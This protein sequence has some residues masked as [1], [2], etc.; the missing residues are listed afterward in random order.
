MLFI[1]TRE[2]KVKEKNKKS[3]KAS[4]LIR[5]LIGEGISLAINT[6]LYYIKK[7]D[8]S[9]NLVV[10]VGPYYKKKVSDANNFI[11]SEYLKMT[12][13]QI[14][15]YINFE[16]INGGLDD[17]G[18]KF[19]EMN[20]GIFLCIKGFPFSQEYKQKIIKSQIEN[21]LSLPNIEFELIECNGIYLDKIEHQKSNLTSENT[22]AFFQELKQ[23]KKKVFE[24]ISNN[25]Q[26]STEYTENTIKNNTNYPFDDNNQNNNLFESNN[27]NGNYGY[28]NNQNNKIVLRNDN[29]EN[30]ED[31][32]NQNN[33]I[34]GTN[35]N[36]ENYEGCLF[37]YEN[38]EDDN[39]QNNNIFGT[40]NNNENYEGCLFGQF[41]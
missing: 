16:K 27:N 9:G 18:I 6:A 8:K 40:N 12:I 24:N 7:S 22:N 29:N 21:N 17:D 33:N 20:F 32:N 4:N 34:F 36:S 26:N 23:M 37:G 35:N 38:E 13:K 41:V 5:D 10:P 39:N 3:E 2:E 15:E 30:K 14:L 25:S 1:V 31:D 11:Y 19:F 28:Y